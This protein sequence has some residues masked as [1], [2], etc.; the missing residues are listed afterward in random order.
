MYVCIH[1]CMYGCMYGSMSAG[2]SLAGF[3]QCVCMYVFVYTNMYYIKCEIKTCTY[4]CIYTISSVKRIQVCVRDM[5]AYAHTHT[6]THTRLIVHRHTCV[7]HIGCEN[8]SS[9]VSHA[10]TCKHAYIHA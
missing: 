6:F 8:D 4:A 10:S 7:V 2:S 5:Q 1:V 3:D 9:D